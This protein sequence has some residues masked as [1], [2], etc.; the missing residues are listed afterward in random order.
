MRVSSVWFVSNSISTVDSESRCAALPEG[1]GIFSFQF[2]R[3]I[4]DQKGSIWSISQLLIHLL[5]EDMK[6]HGLTS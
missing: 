4:S 1:E 3:G 2:T 6:I 5:S